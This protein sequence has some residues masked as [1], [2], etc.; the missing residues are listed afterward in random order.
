MEGLTDLLNT[1]STINRKLNPE[2]EVEGI[3][4]TMFD[5][6]TKL[7]EEVETEIKSYFGDK[8]YKEK[9]PRNVRLSEAPSHGKPVAAYDRFSKGSLA[10]SALAVEFIKRDKKQGK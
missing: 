7:S 8:V 9:I 3:V 1:V 4:L 2:L 6:R 5:G 10:Y